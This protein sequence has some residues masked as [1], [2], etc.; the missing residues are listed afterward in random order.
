MP[1]SNGGVL[2]RSEHRYAHRVPERPSKLARAVTASFVVGGVV[3]AALAV[4]AVVHDPTS[5]A[6]WVA[7]PLGVLLVVW[8]VAFARM[9][10]DDSPDD[11]QTGDEA[12]AGRSGGLSGAPLARLS[13]VIALLVGY[14]AARMVGRPV[15]SSLVAVGGVL[16]LWLMN[17]AVDRWVR[18]RGARD[19]D[20]GP[21]PD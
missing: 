11:D 3:V 12:E 9:S 7:I 4:I 18:R 10:A 6:A 21:A 19:G 14:V 5:D 1:R 20:V 16:A 8:G 2:G 17:R 13:W 15:D